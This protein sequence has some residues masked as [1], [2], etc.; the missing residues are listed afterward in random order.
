MT[1]TYVHSLPSTQL[2]AQNR[3]SPSCTTVDRIVNSLSL[4]A[5]AFA[6]QKPNFPSDRSLDALKLIDLY[7]TEKKTVCSCSLKFGPFF[8]SSSEI[9]CNDQNRS[10][11]IN[12]ISTIFKD[13]GLFVRLPLYPRIMSVMG[14]GL[15]AETKTKSWKP[16]GSLLTFL[17]FIGKPAGNPRILGTLIYLGKGGVQGEIPPEIRLLSLTAL[18]DVVSAGVD[19]VYAQR[20]ADQAR[21]ISQ[22]ATRLATTRSN[23][24]WLSV[25]GAAKNVIGAISLVL[26][27]QIENIEEVQAAKDALLPY[28][29]PIDK[30]LISKVIIGSLIGATAIGIYL[31]R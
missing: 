14:D 16:L 3:D 8:P 18:S 6:G 20:L 15:E 25:E 22:Q 19:P 4:P 27:K 31:K 5:T 10:L 26:A 1:E 17:Q 29:M 9:L 2:G 12:K 30:D 23:P 11:I 28:S 24:I 21:A 7:Y 13:G